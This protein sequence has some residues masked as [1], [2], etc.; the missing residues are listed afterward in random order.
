[1]SH[2]K[3]SWF[4]IKMH[5]YTNVTYGAFVLSWGVRILNRKPESLT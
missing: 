4:A 1:M 3:P 2:V 5:T